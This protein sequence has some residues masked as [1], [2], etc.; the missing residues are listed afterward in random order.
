MGGKFTVEYF[1][2]RYVFHRI[3]CSQSR[4]KSEGQQEI[5]I[6]IQIPW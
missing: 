5:A 6:K 3:S 1:G 2:L 4:L